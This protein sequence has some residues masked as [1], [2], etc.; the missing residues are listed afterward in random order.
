MYPC[1]PMGVLMF[2][3]N[4]FIWPE[5]GNDP[6]TGPVFDKIGAYL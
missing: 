1:K 2:K 5:V 4:T 6:K 3:M